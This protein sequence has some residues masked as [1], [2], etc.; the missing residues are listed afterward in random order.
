MENFRK[1][2]SFIFEKHVLEVSISYL[3]SYTSME[4]ENI[5]H[6]EIRALDEHLFFQA[7][8]N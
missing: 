4:T 8:I 2:F 5:V 6:E 7:R 1:D 3:D